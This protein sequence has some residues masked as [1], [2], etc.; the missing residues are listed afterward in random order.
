MGMMMKATLHVPLGQGR[1]MQVRK[2]P[3]GLAETV[4]PPGS[5]D[6]VFHEKGGEHGSITRADVEGAV[7]YRFPLPADARHL[8]SSA[9]GSRVYVQTDSHLHVLD[10][11]TGQDIGGVDL[12]D[13]KVRPQPDGRVAVLEGNS[14]RWLD[15]DG[16]ETARQEFPWEV[17]HVQPLPGGGL[18]AHGP[19]DYY[20]L[21]EVQVL[22]P[23]GREVFRSEQVR[24]SNVAVTPDG[25][26]HLVEY[27]PQHESHMISLDPATGDSRR[28]QVPTMARAVFAQSDGTTVVYDSTEF[29]DSTFAQYAADGTETRRQTFTRD[30]VPRNFLPDPMRRQ[31]WIV[32]RE[33]PETVLYRMDLQGPAKPAEVVRRETGNLV[34]PP[35]LEDGRVVAFGKQGVTLHGPDGAQQQSFATLREAREAVGD[36]KLGDNWLL[37]ESPR[38][39]KASFHQWIPVAARHVD[40]PDRREFVDAAAAPGKPLR[41]PDRCLD[42]PRPVAADEAFRAMGLED[43]AT[44]Q[45]ML[46][47]ETD[48]A[49]KVGEVAC[50]VSFPGGGPTAR[51]ARDQVTVEVPGREP[52]VH[53]YLELNAALPVKAGEE[54][55]LA[56]AEQAGGTGRALA[57]CHPATRSYERFDVTSRIVGLYGG[58][59]VYAVGS[60]GSVLTIEPAEGPVQAGV[61]L[62]SGI[63]EGDRIAVDEQTVTIGGLVLE[64]RK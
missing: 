34:V 43:L 19:G 63:M 1:F 15:A 51:V 33:G 62:P 28:V 3:T 31:A 11:A 32:T 59:R 37:G 29:S 36:A 53:R 2:F 16:R 21:G 41:G 61:G 26:V 45:R 52:T 38:L 7:R 6:V 55:Y 12:H 49:L 54:F 18:V 20:R 60:N 30:Q 48:G 8:L 46:T 22:G 39:D 56:L 5:D 10:P 24:P 17:G 25:R 4:R 58:D 9:D 14:V 64:R 42:F 35:V 13:A 50:P 23:D 47:R 57:W 44:Y 40:L 27:G